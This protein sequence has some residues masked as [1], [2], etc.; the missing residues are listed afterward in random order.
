MPQSLSP[1]RVVALRA[2]LPDGHIVV[3]CGDRNVLIDSGS[4][5][6]LGR[7]TTV[8]T[9]GR[10]PVQPAVW[11]GVDFD[12]VSRLVGVPLDAI[13]GNDVLAQHSFTLVQ[14]PSPVFH[15]GATPLDSASS[16]T[17]RPITFPFVRRMTLPVCEM[18]IGPAGELVEAVID[19]GAVISL[20]PEAWLDAHA[21]PPV[22]QRH[23]FHLSAE[24]WVEFDTPLYLVPAEIDGQRRTLRVG[25]VPDRFASMLEAVAGTPF[26]V[27]TDLLLQ[28]AALAYHADRQSFAVHV[29]EP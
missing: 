8:F 4:P 9:F 5:T 3:R 13:V 11:P 21:G 28:G 22:G 7:T 23:E 29:D 12:D 27:G 17:M 2:C 10:T 26:L 24:G 14:E 1:T 18:R 15:L 6:T 16:R 20:A 25:R 19:T